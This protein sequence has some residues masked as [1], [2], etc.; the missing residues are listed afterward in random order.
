MDPQEISN[1]LITTDIL[2][3]INDILD[4]YGVAAYKLTDISNQEKINCIDNTCLL[5]TSPSPR[6]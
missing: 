4:T 5:Y 1:T 3:N 2:N 6:D